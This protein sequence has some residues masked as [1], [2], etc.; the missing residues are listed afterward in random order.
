MIPSII[1]EDMS[2]E[3]ATRLQALFR[4]TTPF[5][6]PT[7]MAIRRSHSR[8]EPPDPHEWDIM[9]CVSGGKEY[10]DADRKAKPGLYSRRYSE[11]ILT[12]AVSGIHNIIYRLKSGQN[13]ALRPF[14]YRLMRP[15]GNAQLC[16]LLWTFSI[17]IL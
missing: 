2:I 14:R 11:Q 4:E 8:L 17:N 15:T 16:M 6:K 5:Q 12:Q 1:S 3:D 10:I 9:Q 13:W 7:R